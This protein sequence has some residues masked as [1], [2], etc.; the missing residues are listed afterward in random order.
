MSQVKSKI[1]FFSLVH[2]SLV[3]FSLVGS[4]FT[5]LLQTENLKQTEKQD[6]ERKSR[7]L[8]LWEEGGAAGRRNRSK[9]MKEQET[10][11]SLMVK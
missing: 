9:W 7:S 5:F 3:Y 11:C 4:M 10:M 1:V 8:D 6:W 2:S